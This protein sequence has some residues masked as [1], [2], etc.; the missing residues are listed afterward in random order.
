MPGGS[1]TRTGT[2]Q[3]LMIE[4]LLEFNHYNYQ[5]Q[6]FIGKQLFNNRYKAD[7]VVDNSIIVSLKWQQV[8]GTAEQ[9]VI[10][11]IA[12][13]IKIIENDNFKKAYVV[14]GGNGFSR[15]AKEYLFSQEHRNILKHG[16]LVENIGVED[17]IARLNNHN[18]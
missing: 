5:K 14:I 6:V 3:E 18:L 8:A 16:D 15:N 7:F 9:K 1:G 10:Y 2:G 12:S 11:E 13:L 4:S 17:F